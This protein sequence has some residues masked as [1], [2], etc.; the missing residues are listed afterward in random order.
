MSPYSLNAWN[1]NIFFQKQSLLSQTCQNHKFCIQTL[2]NSEKCEDKLVILLKC[3]V[4]SLLL[5]KITRISAL[6]VEELFVLD[7]LFLLNL[8][9]ARLGLCKF[10][11]QNMALLLLYFLVC[12]AALGKIERLK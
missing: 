1:S 9:L 8:S 3:S 7:E 11:F 12:N 10:F 4:L 6:F 5:M 2:G